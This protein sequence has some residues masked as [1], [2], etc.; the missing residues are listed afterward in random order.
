MNSFQAQVS[1]ITKTFFKIA[2]LVSV[3]LAVPRVFKTELFDGQVIKQSMVYDLTQSYRNGE[4]LGM[5]PLRHVP[6]IWQSGVIPWTEEFPLYS[7]SVAGMSQ[8]LS[9]D[10]VQTGRLLSFLFWIALVVGF[11]FLAQGSNRSSTIQT[12]QL[13]LDEFWLAIA[14]ASSIPVFQIYGTA[15]MPDLPMAA[16]LV[17]AFVFALKDSFRSVNFIIAGI[18]AALA[19]MFKFYAIFAVAAMVIYFFWERK[20][21]WKAWAW[22]ALAVFPSL[23]YLA[24]YLKL[25]I[26]N[27]ITEYAAHFEGGHFGAR[28][29]FNPHFYLRLI[30]WNVVKNPGLIFGLLGLAGF[31]WALK[32]ESIRATNR[33]WL[34]QFLFQLLFMI[35]FSTS[36]FVHDYYGLMFSILIAYFSIQVLKVFLRSQVQWKVAVSLVVFGLGWVLAQART[37]SATQTE[38]FYIFG[39]NSLARMIEIAGKSSDVTGILMGDRAPEAL[40]LNLGLSAYIFKT[41]QWNNSNQREEWMKRLDDPRMEWVALFLVDSSSSSSE[42]VEIQDL[43]RKKEWSLKERSRLRDHSEVLFFTKTGN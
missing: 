34:L 22:G 36:F 16:C 20:W 4:M 5:F 2:V 33:F 14:V 9:L 12:G 17:W 23:T 7:V 21:K 13:S 8:L 28:F 43:L 15:F 1:F 31:I 29:L 32:T 40:A 27:P 24:I 19:C 3:I 26:P 11:G 35:T 30:T 38:E 37:H 25:G 18:F 10:L 6:E 41:H 42:V 39:R